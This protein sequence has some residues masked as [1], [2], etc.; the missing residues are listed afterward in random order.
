MET[1][2]CDRNSKNPY[3]RNRADSNMTVARDGTVVIAYCAATQAVAQIVATSVQEIAV[4]AVL[5]AVI[6]TNSLHPV[7]GPM[8]ISSGT[9]L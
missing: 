8:A 1:G 4:I 3:A 9:I 6:V 2:P 7:R 5:V